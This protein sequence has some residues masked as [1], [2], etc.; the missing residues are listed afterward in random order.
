MLLKLVKPEL[1]TAE[2][3]Q[4]LARCLH[5]LLSGSQSQQP[6]KALL[7]SRE[8]LGESPYI[9]E[10]YIQGLSKQFSM[11]F[12]VQEAR[13][14]SAIGILHTSSR[15][16]ERIFTVTHGMPLAMKLIISQFIAGI[17]LDTE[18][19]RLQ[20]AK[21]QELYRFIYMRLWFKLSIPAQKILVAIDAFTSSA[22]RLM[23][24]TVS[25]TGDEEFET[26]IP[27]LVRMALIEPSDHPTA[28]QRRYS[29]HPVTRWFINGPT[30]LT[31]R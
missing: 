13:Q 2:R 17:P 24:Q 23:L 14:R 5:D 10:Y 8:R 26:G 6:S 16:L 11:E 25:K 9:S 30:Q 15:L 19:D 31:V 7:T 3:Y 4:D 27:E 1:E 12:I 22:S 18:L 29:I 21:E 28:A 20:G